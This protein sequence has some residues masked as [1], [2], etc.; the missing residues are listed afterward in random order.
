MGTAEYGRDHL[1]V[2]RDVTGPP[3]APSVIPCTHDDVITP[4]PAEHDERACAEQ[5][6]DCACGPADYGREY[7]E[8]QLRPGFAMYDIVTLTG[9][10]LGTLLDIMRAADRR[11]PW[12]I[13][14]CVD[15]G[16]KIK[17]DEGVWT[18]PLGRIDPDTARPLLVPRAPGESSSGV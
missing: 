3:G 2:G 5:H 9:E 4:Q 11:L 12:Q 17:I 18:P 15:G 10:D 1:S 16:V 13:K 14:I 8:I 7:R 6:G